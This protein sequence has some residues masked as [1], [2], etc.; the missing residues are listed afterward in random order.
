MLEM[1]PEDRDKMGEAGREHTMKNYN[2][3]DFTKRWPELL[4]DIH[5]RYGS[6]ETRKGYKNWTFEEVK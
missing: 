3:E 6:W 5:N 1:S 4:E 2:F